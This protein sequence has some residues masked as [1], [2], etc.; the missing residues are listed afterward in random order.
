MTGH[1]ILKCTECGIIITQCRCMES[2]K[3]LRWGVCK[4]CEAENRLKDQET[5]IKD[6][7]KDCRFF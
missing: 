6:Q 7:R 5:T 4:K 1:F 2:G 3:E